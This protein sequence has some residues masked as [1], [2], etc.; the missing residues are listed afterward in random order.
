MSFPTLPYTDLQTIT[1]YIV[2][3]CLT[4][5]WVPNSVLPITNSVLAPAISTGFTASTVTTTTISCGPISY[6]LSPALLFSV[7]VDSTAL[8]ITVSSTSSSD[9]S[10]HSVNLIATLDNYVGIITP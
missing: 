5:T 2:D 7:I 4:T 6:A 8:T 10:S 1:I 3:P 9:I